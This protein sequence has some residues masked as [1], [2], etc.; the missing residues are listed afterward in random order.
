MVLG[1]AVE[2][3]DELL[4]GETAEQSLNSLKA[5]RKKDSSTICSDRQSS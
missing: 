4:E 3:F 1:G 2:A 5:I